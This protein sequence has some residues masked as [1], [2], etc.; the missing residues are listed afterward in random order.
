MGANTHFPSVGW[1]HFCRGGHLVRPKLFLVI[2]DGLV[3]ECS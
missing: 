2:A 1:I 3:M